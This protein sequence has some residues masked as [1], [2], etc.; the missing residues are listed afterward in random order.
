MENEFDIHDRGS[1]DKE[2]ERALRPSYF[3][4][5]NGQEKVVENLKVF[6]QAAR[7]RGE[8]LTIF[9]SSALRVLEKQRSP[10]SLPMSLEST[11]R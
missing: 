9:C 8:R 2:Y 4:G 3:D 6:V 11:S 1:A 5:F 7:M 10:A